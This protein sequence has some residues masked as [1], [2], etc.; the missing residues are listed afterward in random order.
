MESHTRFLKY[1][2]TAKAT[3]QGF[4]KRQVLSIT[5][6]MFDPLGLLGSVIVNAK[7]IMQKLWLEKLDWVD[8]IP[9]SLAKTWNEFTSFFTSLTY[10]V[11]DA[12][13]VAYGSCIYIRSVSHTEE[14]LVRILTAKSR[15]AP[16]KT[17]TI[18]RLELCAALLMVRLVEKVIGFLRLQVDNVTYCTDSTIVLS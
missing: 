1:T 16:I 4:T 8:P 10:L 15:V 5:S 7:I 2:T 6:Q 13:Q 9:D 14:T 17:L 18:P 11:N 3:S 12:S